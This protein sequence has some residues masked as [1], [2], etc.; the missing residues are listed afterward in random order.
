ME[1]PDGHRKVEQR[2]GDGSRL[3]SP[4]QRALG[5]VQV[6]PGPAG[7]GGSLAGPAGAEEP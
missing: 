4:H 6:L 7:Q 5:G 1:E 3:L 2:H